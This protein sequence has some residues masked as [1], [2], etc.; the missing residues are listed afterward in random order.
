MTPRP[1]AWLSWSSGK[2]SAWA[3]H[4]A[5]RQNDLDIVALFSTVNRAFGRVAM[6]G[7]REALIDLQAERAGLPLIKVPIPYPCPNEQYE[8]AM[9][10]AMDRARGEG[11][12]H[13]V[14]GDLFLQDI[15][16]YREQQLARC[17]MTPVF[18]IWGIETGKLAG[19][20]V[21]GGLEAWLACIDPRK[22]DRAFAGRKFNSRLLA[23]LPTGIDPCG[24]NGEFHTFASAGPMFGSPISLATGEIVERDGFVF[25]DLLPAPEAA[26]VR[27]DRTP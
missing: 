7:V 6:H 16:Q 13:V 14:F 27:R 24:E 9:A 25:T 1:K 17:A 23:E 3:L 10:A 15:R 4:V 8:Q 21:A 19:D 12:T 11:V 22:L 20:M 26:P 2:D 18:P 5:R